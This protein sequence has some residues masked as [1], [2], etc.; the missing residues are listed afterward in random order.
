MH[1]RL[2]LCIGASA[3]PRRAN[4]DPWHRRARAT[5]PDPHGLARPGT[6]IDI[7][8]S[9]ADTARR[10]VVPSILVGLLPAD[11]IPLWLDSGT[12]S[13]LTKSQ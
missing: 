2:D 1:C 10:N 9:W 13:G 12:V 11:R 5:G 8:L 6:G 7:S 4:G 3:V